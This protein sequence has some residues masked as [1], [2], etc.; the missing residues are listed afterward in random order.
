MQYQL[1]FLSTI[2]RQLQLQSQEFS[3]IHLVYLCTFM[4]ADG[5]M[6]LESQLDPYD[7]IPTRKYVSA[8]LYNRG[9]PL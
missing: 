4:N 2:L 6:V 8:Y 1:M 5:K 9:L 7:R 3:K